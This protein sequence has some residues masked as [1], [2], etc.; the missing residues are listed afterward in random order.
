MRR[1]LLTLM[2]ALV[3]API[4]SA[5]GGPE[6]RPGDEVGN[7]TVRPGETLR[8]ITKLYLG[9]EDLWRENYRL[10]PDLADPDLLSIGRQ[11]RVIIN[12]E[13]PPRVARV[14]EVSRKVNKKPQPAPWT[15][16][17]R[18]DLLREQDGIRTFR[19]AS[20]NIEFDD[21]TRL[22]MTEDSLI[23]LRRV[24]ATLTGIKQ[25]TIEI[26]T[27][28]ADLVARPERPGASDIEILIG[29]T[30][31]RPKAGAGG[32]AEGR[33][34]KDES[35]GAQLMVYAGESQ[36][37]SGGAEVSVPKGMGTTVEEG[38]APNPPERLL[39]A[40]RLTDDG[41]SWPYPNPRFRWQEVKGAEAYVVEVC[42][43]RDCNL[44][45]EQAKV[46]TTAWS[47]TALPVG[48]HHWRVTAV[49]ASG[50]DGFPAATRPVAI[51]GDKEDLEAPVVAV[52]IEGLG[53]SA[54][55]DTVVLGAGGRLRLEAHDD[56]AGVAE[57]TYRWGDGG[58]QT[59][60]DRSLD[61]P[62][63]D[64]PH[65]LDFQATDN[66]GRESQMWSVEVTSDRQGAEPPTPVRVETTP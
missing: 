22:S 14:I 56:V 65:R 62:N 7:H 49:S 61:P 19:K 29:G 1:S 66:I 48:E 16:A 59:W 41:D 24:G 10:N 9:T 44:R 64:G 50:L 36:V 2:F 25:E 33:L 32:V 38:K 60:Q 30:T 8:G 12:R 11:L 63:G 45:L 3:L 5:Q 42:P 4:A 13:L 55:A 53:R 15:A 31:A 17:R 43:D 57:V 27:G 6:P 34:R 21:G 47:A 39:P 54:S 20:T 40:P 52:Q 26:V 37:E 18:G 35:G 58:W 51:L 28:Q 46:T 23:F